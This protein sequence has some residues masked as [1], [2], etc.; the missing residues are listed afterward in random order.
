MSFG[1]F[2]LKADRVEAA[3]EEAARDEAARDEAA[4]AEGDARAEND[5]R[6][7]AARMEDRIAD[8]TRASSDARDAREKAA[9]DEAARAEAAARDAEAMEFDEPSVPPEKVAPPSM[10]EFEAGMAAPITGKARPTVDEVATLGE[11]TSGPADAPVSRD[12]VATLGEPG[13]GSAEDVQRQQDAKIA[14][15]KAAATDPP[16]SRFIEVGGEIIDTQSTAKAPPAS[17]T[18]VADNAG[19][20]AAAGEPEGATAEEIQGQKDAKVL[21]A[22]APAFELAPPAKPDTGATE[23]DAADEDPKAWSEAPSTS[24]GDRGVAAQDKMGQD[25]GGPAFE[26][27]GADAN[28]GSVFGSS[29]GAPSEHDLQVVTDANGKQYLMPRSVAEDYRFQIEASA[30]ARDKAQNQS[31][32]DKIREA[33]LTGGRDYFSARK[34]DL[35]ATPQ[36]PYASAVDVS[37]VSQ[38]EIAAHAKAYHEQ[39]A[40]A[41]QAA[42]E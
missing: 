29:A 4:R 22:D 14:A 33:A 32:W 7:E 9:R 6:E 36:F 16:A 5:A 39:R 11:P 34:E 42:K 27:A 1:G 28:F 8:A 10:A 26:L 17:S 18:V 30:A 41:E 13:G 25:K 3:R 15:D 31:R 12:D 21:A 38:S 20:A 40:T 23:P 2:G 35:Q 24:P 37:G 19:L